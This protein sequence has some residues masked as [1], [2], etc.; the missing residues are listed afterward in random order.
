MS[1]PELVYKKPCAV[2]ESPVWDAQAGAL[3]WV[4]IVRKTIHRWV[5]RS[6]EHQSWLLQEMVGSIALGIDGCVVA[7]QETAIERIELLAG[8]E[9]RSIRKTPVEHAIP[10]MRCN[11]GRCDPCGRFV[12][13]TM[14]NDMSAG[15][16]VGAFLSLKGDRI[17]RFFEPSVIVGNGLAFSLDGRSMYVSDSHPSVQTVWVCDYDLGTG[18]ASRPRVFADFKA[19]DGRPD[20][21]AI[22]ADGCY[23]ICANDGGAVYRFTPSG[24]LDR[25]VPLPVKKPSMCAFGGANFDTLFVTSIRPEGIDLSDQPLAGCVFA[26]NPGVKG[27]EEPKFAT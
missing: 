11:D 5:M 1:T 3:W 16:S 27:R 25:R 17:E 22:D 9:I 26:V 18:Y 13:S 10:G 6:G 21:A 14:F 24:Q 12:C 4:D 23:W 2:G 15:K 20:G 19:L 7:A 8:G